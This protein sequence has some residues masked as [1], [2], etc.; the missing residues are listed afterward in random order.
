[1]DSKKLKL[2]SILLGVGLFSS[3]AAAS[4]YVNTLDDAKKLKLITLLVT[5]DEF[6][7]I[8]GDPKFGRLMIAGRAAVVNRVIERALGEEDLQCLMMETEE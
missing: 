4:D 5:E 7:A 3:I 6:Q 1:M 8:S 2:A